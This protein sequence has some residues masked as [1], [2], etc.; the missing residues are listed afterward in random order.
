MMTNNKIQY[1]YKRFLQIQNSLN[2]GSLFL[3]CFHSRKKP[4]LSE[5]TMI[6]ICGETCNFFDI[7]DYWCRW[8]D[9]AK[10]G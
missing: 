2:R 3:L 7:D 5:G 10:G 4:C 1:V 8:L 9:E 6:E